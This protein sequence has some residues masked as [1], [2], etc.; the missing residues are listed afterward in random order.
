MSPS[1]PTYRSKLKTLSNAVSTL[2]S[3]CG[4]KATTFATA[5]GPSNQLSLP[6]W[7]QANS[8]GTVHTLLR[9]SIARG[10]DLGGSILQVTFCAQLHLVNASTKAFVL[11]GY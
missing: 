5:G 6:S 9:F 7:P 2:A 11:T 1:A 4:A 3:E 10:K 8:P